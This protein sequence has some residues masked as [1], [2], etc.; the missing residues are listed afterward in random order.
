MDKQVQKEIAELSEIIREKDGGKKYAKA[1]FNIGT[2]YIEEGNTEKAIEH[3]NKI[4][5]NDDKEL[6]AKAQF[7]IGLNY[8]KQGNTEKATEYWNKI[9]RNDDKKVFASVSQVLKKGGLFI[10]DFL[11][12]KWL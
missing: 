2:K 9:I 12:E 3:W 8:D 5:R 1:Q 6:F 10:L 4:T 7:N 11:N